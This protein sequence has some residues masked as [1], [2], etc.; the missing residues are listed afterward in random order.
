MPDGL[1]S[2]DIWFPRASFPASQPESTPASNCLA[3]LFFMDGNLSCISG[4][5]DFAESG[6]LPTSVSKS[7]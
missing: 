1:A 5:N 3:A 2:F 4:N 6:I 7:L